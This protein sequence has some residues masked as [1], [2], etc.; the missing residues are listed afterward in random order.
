MGGKD[1]GLKTDMLLRGKGIGKTANGI[2]FLGDVESASALCALKEHVFDEMSDP[3][4]ERIFVARAGV[5]PDS[6][7]NRM[8]E[9][10]FFRYYSDP[11]AEDRFLVQ[12][13]P[14]C[15]IAGF[16][17]PLL[18]IVAESING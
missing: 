3:P 7:G 17:S 18:L 4:L 9:W 10:N 8:G 6:G 2:E 16:K 12:F 14:L 11:I 13:P 1:F 5:Y 15:A